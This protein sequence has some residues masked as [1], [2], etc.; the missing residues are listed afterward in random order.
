LAA[1]SDTIVDGC[2]AVGPLKMA[3]DVATEPVSLDHGEITLGDGPGFDVAIDAA[4]LARVRQACN[5]MPS[6]YSVA[7]SR[8]FR[9]VIQ[10]PIPG[11]GH[12]P[13][14][15]GGAARGRSGSKR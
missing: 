11:D 14:V 6:R 2:E 12:P 3:A 5:R 10:E 13:S 7:V 9:Q 1:V 8:S 4:A 15:V